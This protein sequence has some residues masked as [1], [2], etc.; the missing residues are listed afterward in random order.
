MSLFG[1]YIS[2]PSENPGQRSQLTAN[3]MNNKDKVLFVDDEIN[4]LNAYR[5]ALRKRFSLDVAEGGA[6]ALQMIAT[7]GPY[8][9]LV[10]DMRM[11]GM[12]GVELLAKARRVAP[13]TVRIMLTGNQ[14]Q[15]TAIDAINQGDIYRFLNKPC[16]PE[17]LAAAID[18]AMEQH[19]LLTME[20]ELL[21]KTVRGSIHLLTEILSLVNPEAFG[22]TV[23]IQRYVKLVAHQLKQPRPWWWDTLAMLSQVGCVILP[24]RVLEKLARNRELSMEEEQLVNQHPMVAADLIKHIPRFEEIAEA[25]SCQEKHFDGGGLPLDGRKGTDIP[26]GARVLKAVMDFER[27]ESSGQSLER[28]FQRLKRSKGLYDPAVLKALETVT[29]GAAPVEPVAVKVAGLLDGMVL[30]EDLKTLSG[31]LIVCKGSEITQS[32]RRRLMSFAHE[33]TIKEPFMVL[34]PVEEQDEEA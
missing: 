29:L 8:A 19:R 26:L 18:S 22:R 9:V 2:D 32:V 12:N 33:G 6:K 30:V 4:V 28:C 10:A 21:Q 11:P 24:P 15:Q 13:H 7:Q 25:I 20:K 1:R 5:R 3:R 34:P 27:L 31:T 14:D 23:R 17:N 16:K